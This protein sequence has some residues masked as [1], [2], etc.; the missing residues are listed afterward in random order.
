M[1]RPRLHAATIAGRMRSDA[2]LLTLVGLVVAL[3]TML[4]AAVAPLTERTADRAVAASV[5]DAG[6]RAA[7]VATLP[8]G[9]DDPRG[10]KRQPSSATEIRQD[11]RYA[12]HELGSALAGVL[13]PAVA[14][15]T[16]TPLQLLDAGPGRYLQPVYVDTPEGPPSVRYTAGGAPRA[17]VGSRRGRLTVR[18]GGAPWPVQVAVSEET[19]AALGVGPGD[20]LPAMDAQHREVELR[21]SGVY[22]AT[23]AEDDAWQVGPELLHPAQGVS[24]GIQQVSGDALVSEASLPDL[25]VGVPADDLTQRVVFMPRP[26]SVH[27]RD[28]RALEQAIASLQSSA[29][30]AH[31]DISWDS[32]FD[33]FVEDAGAQVASARGQ[34]QVLLLGLLACVFLLLVLSAQLL[35]RRRTASLRL[36]RERGATLLGISLELL[37]EAA[38]VTTAGAAVGVAATWLFLGEAGWGWVLPVLLAALAS[39]PVLGA[40]TASGATPR[41]APANRSAR[42]AA[43]R[44][45]GLRRVAVELAVLAAAALSFVALRQRGVVGDGSRDS[46]ITAAGAATWW[47]VVGTLV[48]L[49]LLPPAMRL[50]L[51][52]SRRS[53]GGVRFFVAARLAQTA[54][55]ALPLLVVT[56]AVAQLT[57]GVALAATERAGQSSGARLAVG[58]DARLTSA[59]DPS[60]AET[61][62]AVAGAPGVEAVASG[63]VADDVQA[64]APGTADVVRLVVV[65]AAAY[66]RLLRTS[67]LP[68]AAEVGRLL[69]RPAGDGVPALLSG[70]DPRLRDRL[71]VRWQDSTVPLDVVG[72]APRVDASVGP[73]VVVDAQAF[74]SVGADAVPD[75][76][77]AAGPG[78]AAALRA[79][80]ASPQSV[81]SYAG[82]LDARRRAPLPSALV[83]LAAVSSAL[84]LLFAVLAVVL[85]A[86]AESTTRAESLGRLRS[87]GLP[88]RDLR[89]V[90]TGELVVPV[91][92]AAAA[93]LAFGVISARAMFGSFSLER[94]TGQSGP[95]DLVLPWWTVLTCVVLVATVGVVALLEWRALRRRGLA[96]LLRG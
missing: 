15:L 78:A 76:V 37:V 50:L 59:P 18:P 49:R 7:V 14:T 90:L 85:S 24:E 68:G 1:L 70:G 13:R 75:T 30:R 40:L 66:Q 11:T 2:P 77:W 3:T 16:S 46:G 84:L 41:R 72:T 20:R 88:D 74:A 62:H 19:A 27:W 81:V 9:Y 21:I 33:R 22:V 36:S 52:A 73:V 94:I 60:V 55:R 23:D 4:T 31:G 5:R 79:V 96:A 32:L 12:Q 63:R 80:A 26:T 86:A 71:A 45:K 58:G 28:S 17:S 43:A 38:L 6:L 44:A 93:G 91:L 89:R 51:R 34:A 48:L 25:R 61:A 56:V 67:G 95:P 42:R 8:K 35:A 10:K 87:L 54:A 29:G 69:N 57:V 92:V 83:G 64:S 53:T 82:E 47:T 65:D 39:A